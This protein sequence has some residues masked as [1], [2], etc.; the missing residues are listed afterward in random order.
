MSVFL[1]FTHFLYALRRFYFII[2]SIFVI[3]CIRH[4]FHEFFIAYIYFVVIVYYHHFIHFS[5]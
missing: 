3:Y 5:N 4:C 2:V 1:G